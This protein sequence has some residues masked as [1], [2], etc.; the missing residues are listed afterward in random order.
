MYFDDERN[1]FVQEI[2]V[3]AVEY[4]AYYTEPE[5]RLPIS[6]VVAIAIHESGWGTSRFALEGNNYF[7]MKTKSEDPEEYMIPNE[8]KKV[9]LAKYKTTCSSVYAFMDLLSKSKKYKGFREKL[10]TQWFLDEINYGILIK[11][12]NKYSKDK[13]WRKSIMKIIEQIEVK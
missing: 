13:L 3:C 2:G 9:R 12:L 11:T 6:L 4:N 5:Q 8:N 7:G 1:D 10:M